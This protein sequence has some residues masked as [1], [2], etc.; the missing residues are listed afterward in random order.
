MVREVYDKVRKIVVVGAPAVIGPWIIF[1]N[2]LRDQLSVHVDE[3][4]FVVIPWEQQTG[5]RENTHQ[6]VQAALQG[7]GVRI[8]FGSSAQV[9][10]GVDKKVSERNGNALM[11]GQVVER[12]LEVLAGAKLTKSAQDVA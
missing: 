8:V 2:R 3:T 4:G 10:P 7:R 1:V 5:E 6:T 9:S 12:L 11:G